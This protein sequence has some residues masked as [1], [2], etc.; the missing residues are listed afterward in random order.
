[1]ATWFAGGPA[2]AAP[3]RAPASAVTDS[4]SSSSAKVKVVALLRARS[5]CAASAVPDSA[6][7]CSTKLEEAAAMVDRGR[8]ASGAEEA[9]AAWGL[10]ARGQSGARAPEQRLRRARSI[11]LKGERCGAAREVR[12]GARENQ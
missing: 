10:G 4:R 1:M 12:R 7:A 6:R 8:A 3:P 2:A 9:C 5:R 11:T